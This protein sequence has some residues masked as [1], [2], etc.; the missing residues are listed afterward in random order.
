[1]PYVK[2]LQ[3]FKVFP[4]CHL[5]LTPPSSP[6]V[7][8]QHWNYLPRPHILLLSPWQLSRPQLKWHQLRFLTG[9]DVTDDQRANL[10]KY[11]WETYNATEYLESFPF[12]VIGCHGGPPDDPPFSVAG[13][14][15][16]C[17]DAKEF[18]FITPIGEFAQGDE[19]EVDDDILDQI[20]RWKYLQRTSSFI[21][22]ISGLSV[23]ESVSYGQCLWWR[24]PLSAKR[25]TYVFVIVP[26]CGQA[27]V[28]L[29][30]SPRGT[31]KTLPRIRS[32]IKHV[33]THHSTTA[34]PVLCW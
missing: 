24:C 13:A 22:P 16:I 10:H 33:Y 20:V 9:R 3:S 27:F 29:T 31:T 18:A 12:L 23:R 15:A 32:T 28:G 4:L 14:I 2:E 19:I 25:S 26:W 8:R 5:H 21:L 17:R 1:M 11:L 34:S 30:L 6:F 7:L